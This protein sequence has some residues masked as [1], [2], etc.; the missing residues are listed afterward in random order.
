MI[1]TSVAMPTRTIAIL[2][3]QCLGGWAY[4]KFSRTA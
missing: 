3:S 4:R 2:S 1:G